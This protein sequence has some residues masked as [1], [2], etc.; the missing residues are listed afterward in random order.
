MQIFNRSKP[1]DVLFLL[2]VQHKGEKSARNKVRML[3]CDI[4][5]N[6]YSSH[7]SRS[8]YESAQSDITSMQNGCSCFA[9]V[10]LET[11]PGNFL[12]TVVKISEKE[13]WALENITDHAIK[14]GRLPDILKKYLR[15]IIRQAAASRDNVISNSRSTKSRTSN[16]KTSKVLN[17]LPY[18]REQDM[19]ISMPIYKA[20][21][22]YPLVILKS[23]P[24]K[25]RGKDQRSMLVLDSDGD[26]SVINVPVRLA[27]NVDS[28]LARN[29]KDKNGSLQA[30][31]YK[32]RRGR[33][34]GFITINETQRNALDTIARY[35]EETG[36][37]KKSVPAAART[38]INLA[39]R[40]ASPGTG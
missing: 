21:S 37:G 31:V 6:V 16:G 9:T 32:D 17:R 35:Y 19:E 3:Y 27:R 5:G 24:Q 7:I 4:N 34:I 39:A 15:P 14:K 29:D 2:P 1:R 11:T 18:Y 23:L 26:M 10:G 20:E 38:V 22:S 30:I 33:K 36:R 8:V 12:P 25:E 13:L 28:K 40:Q